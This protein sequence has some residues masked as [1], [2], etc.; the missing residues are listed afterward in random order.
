MIYTQQEMELQAA[1]HAA[2]Q[3][4]AAARTAPKTRGIDKLHTL[5][6][7][8]EEKDALSDELERLAQAQGID[9]YARDALNLRAAQA[10]VLIGTAEGQ[11]GLGEGC[12][13]CH[14]GSC[15][16]CARAGGACVFD[17]MDLGI[18]LGSAAALAADQRVDTR[19]MYSIGKAAL[20]LGLMEPSVTLIVAVPISVSGKSPFFDRKKRA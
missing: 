16:G 17:A 10:V 3:I 8:G 1:L 11:R 19:V 5:V 14:F 4:C 18:A 6:L 12:G 9:F 15:E 2:A 7:T 20:S 13:Y